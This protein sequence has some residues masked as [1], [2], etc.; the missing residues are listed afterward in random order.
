MHCTMNIGIYNPYF[1]SYGGGERYTLTL[2]SHWSQS[3]NVSVFWDDVSMLQ[4]ARNRFS[5]DVSHIA[6]VPNIFHSKNIFSKLLQSSR[7]DLILFL[8][9]GSVPM[10][11]ARR[12][13]LHFQ[14]PFAHVRL[15][16][17]KG[18]RYQQ[19]VCNSKFTH[20]HLDPTL[21][22]PRNII[23]PPVD[24]RV[25][26]RLQKQKTI[27]AVGRF[28]ALYGAKKYE[29]LIDAFVSSKTS[30]QGWR[31]KIAGGLLASDAPYIETLR[32]RAIGSPID[33]YP[34]CTFE[35]L[36]RLYGEASVFWHAA[37]F[38]ESKP[39]RMEH[40]GISTV[41][42][43]SAGCIPVV[44]NGGGQKEIIRHGV[45]GFLWNSA[46]ELIAYTK[47]VADDRKN[48]NRL[49]PAALKRS[50]DFSIERF[51]ASFDQLLKD[52]MI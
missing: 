42:A 45:D 28:S 31:L 7:Y 13:I 9:D 46:E 47:N 24:T 10:S 33:F 32:K 1:D 37:G 3:H 48:T 17:W 5:L 21:D 2:A 6:T 34:N 49:R 35:E 11:M 8:S 44:F 4:T 26:T 38:G 12:N 22:I 14:V 15:P 43:M 40:F 50:A 41:E 27:L 23:Y 52:V 51:Y 39:E 19:I 18:N 16:L 29:V 36:Q 25:F 30:L 20:T